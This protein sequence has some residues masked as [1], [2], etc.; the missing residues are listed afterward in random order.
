ML[1]QVQHALLPSSP[2]PVILDEWA[3]ISEALADPQRKR[4]LQLAAFFD[5]TSALCPNRPCGSPVPAAF[6]KH[7]PQSLAFREHYLY[8]MM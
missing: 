3:A 1:H 4:E 5:S 8:H 6:L 7:K 2:L